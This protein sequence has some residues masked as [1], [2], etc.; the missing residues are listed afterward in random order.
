MVLHD[1]GQVA[2]PE[3]QGITIAPGQ[4]THL[5]IRQLL[6]TKLSGKYRQCAETLSLNDNIFAAM[7]S[8]A[9]STK[10]GPTII[11]DRDEMLKKCF[12]RKTAIYIK[13]RK[14]TVHY[15]P[16]YQKMGCYKL[17]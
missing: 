8:V 2:F 5:G 16:S 3:D 10:V 9:Y 11:T 14:D 7:N 12:R 13:S 17:F 4:A 15:W 1:Q 6:L